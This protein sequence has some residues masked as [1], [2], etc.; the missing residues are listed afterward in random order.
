MIP[1][2]EAEKL[3]NQV[4]TDWGTELL[5]LEECYG[6][7]LA[8][9]VL[10][11]RDYPPYHRVTMDGFAFFSGETYDS[12][13]VQETQFAGDAPA[14]L[15]SGNVVEVMTG[16][17]LPANADSVVQYEKCQE[18]QERLVSTEV[19][20]TPFLNVHQK[21]SDATAGQ[22]LLDKGTELNSQHIAVAASVG[23]TQLLV[24]RKPKVLLISTGNE[25]VSHSNP[26]DFQIRPSNTISLASVLHSRN[27][28]CERRHLPDDKEQI[29]KALEASIEQFDL[30][31]FSGGVSMGKA[32]FIP[33][34]LDYLGVKKIFHR[35]AQKPGKPLWFGHRGKQ[36]FFGLPGNPVSTSVCF[37]RYVMPLLGLKP[38]EKMPLNHDFERK[39]DLTLFVPVKRV[40]EHGKTT[41]H[42]I[43][44]NGSGDFI[45]TSKADGFVELGMEKSVYKQGEKLL[46]YA[47]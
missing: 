10:S 1:V 24:K 25:L 47:F 9:E 29:T 28:Y 40:Q 43:P 33:A 16:A 11:D 44:T 38:L 6:R 5:P 13:K 14:T 22:K 15:L 23:K 20:R 42:L 21:G 18:Q 45:S 17:S 4:F 7:T 31:L 46:F 41:L 30:F 32:D 12:Y 26:T 39:K 37:V 3:I 2:S 34:V 8:E 19:V 36:L 35:I 27:I